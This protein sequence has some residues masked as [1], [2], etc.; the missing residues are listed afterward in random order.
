MPVFNSLPIPEVVI[1]NRSADPRE[2][3]D[4]GDERPRELDA[5]RRAL[6][7]FRE[8][9]DAQSERTRRLLEGR[10]DEELLSP[11]AC[12]RLKAMGYIQQACP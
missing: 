4:V 1:N 12:E 8:T 2:T 6:E 5:E 10:S 9:I 7:E 3:R 11:A